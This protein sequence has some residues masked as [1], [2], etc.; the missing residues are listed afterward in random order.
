MTIVAA[1]QAGLDF[2]HQVAADP[3][4]EIVVDN[5]SKSY[6]STK[7]AKTVVHGCSFSIDRAKLTV[8]IGPSGCGKS[9]LIRLLAGFE[10]PT[11][12]TLTL[13]GEPITG[14][15]RDRLVLFQET[16]LFPWMT[17]YDNILYGP[18]AR[19]EVTPAT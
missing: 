12:G 9:T 14:P 10:K 17:T 1:P 16:A 15:A 6:G 4:A 11:S 3:A 13:N 8:M 18:R 7:F 19:G 5:V 2:A